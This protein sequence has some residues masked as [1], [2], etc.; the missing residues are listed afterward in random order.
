MPRDVHIDRSVLPLAEGRKVNWPDRMLF[1]QWHRGDRPEP[2]RNCAVRTQRHKLIDGKELYDM[3]A[4]PGEKQ[5]IAGQNPAV[6]ARLRAGYE[7]WLRDVSSDRNFVPPRIY[8]GTAHENP[9][10][11]TR[12]DARVPADTKDPTPPWWEVDVKRAAKYDVTVTIDPAECEGE[13]HFDLGGATLQAALG[14]GAG[15]C[16]FAGV[17]LREGPGQLRAFAKCGTAKARA[18]RFVEIRRVG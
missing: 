8:I 10:V 17:T 16:R 2:F 7:A 13:A 14:K 3:E 9:V 4:D 6:V 15:E 12:Q 18:A 11:F 1:T 5:D